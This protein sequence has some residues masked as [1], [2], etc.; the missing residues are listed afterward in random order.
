MAREGRRPRPTKLKL[1]EGNPGKR[2]LNE[3]EPKAPP[4]RPIAPPDLSDDA[5][6]EW[7]YIVPKLDA[8]GILTKADRRNL[9][10]LCEQVSVFNEATAWIQDKGIIVAGRNKGEAVKNPAVQIQR[11][12]ARLISTFSRMFG[13]DPADRASL[14]VG[15]LPA[16]AAAALGAVLAGD[17]ATPR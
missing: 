3:A 6:K 13:L 14:E 17:D 2:P 11:D 10:I 5:M 4:G 12:A 16:D 7:K 8:M 15:G 1:I 9:V